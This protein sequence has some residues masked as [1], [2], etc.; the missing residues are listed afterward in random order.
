MVRYGIDGYHLLDAAHH[1]DAPQWLA[2]IPAVQ[3]LRLIWIQQFYRDTDN[4]GQEVRRREHAPD[5]DGVPPGRDRV[6][7]PYDLDARYSI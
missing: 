5:G 2:Q 1:P 7:S 3:T 4:A 6:I